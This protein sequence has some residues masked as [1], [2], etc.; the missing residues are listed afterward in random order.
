VKLPPFEYRRAES[1]DH[2]ISLLGESGD[3]AKLLA[4][5]QSLL[6]AMAFRIVR[7]SVLVDIGRLRSLDGIEAGPEGLRIGALVRHAAL[8]RSVALEGPWSVLRTAAALVGHHPI[9]VRGTF[10]GSLAHADPAAELAVVALALD[11]TV[12]AHSAGGGERAIPAAD[13]FVGPYMTA[14]GSTEMVTEVRFPA[15]PSG[16]RTSFVEL[17]E[18]SGDFALA[19]V[20]AGVVRTEGR[21]VWARIGLGSVGATPLHA[22]RAENVLIGSDGGHDAI[23]GA[24]SEAAAQCEPSSDPQASAEYRRELVAVLVRRALERILEEDR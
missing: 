24:A 23:E 4:G 5:G 22:S 11:A 13:F 9:R 12:V 1:V 2:A 17:T 14:L 20:C 6:A 7:P 3:E 18:R 21:I 19:S 8:E 10:G 15:A 16:A